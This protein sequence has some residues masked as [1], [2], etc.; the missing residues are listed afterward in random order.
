M[1]YL[2]IACHL[3]GD[4]TI[5]FLPYD[6]AL[7]KFN[8]MRDEVKGLDE[9][10]F[11][12]GD[13]R[14][15]LVGNGEAQLCEGMDPDCIYSVSIGRA[16]RGQFLAYFPEQTEDFTIAFAGICT[17]DYRDE[18]VDLEDPTTWVTDSGEVLYAEDVQGGLRYFYYGGNT[19]ATIVLGTIQ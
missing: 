10:I 11:T 4:S 7:A 13:N 17:G 12:D 18:Q 8:A 9:D 15:D 6:K 5:E 16:P 14:F 19:G 3:T 2:A 1:Y